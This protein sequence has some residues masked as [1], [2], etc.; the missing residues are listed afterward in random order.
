[1]TKTTYCP[2]ATELRES[3][4]LF[5]YELTMFHFT[6]NALADPSMESNKLLKNAILE[7]ALIHTRNLYEFFCGKES[8]NNNIIAG[9]FAKNSDGTPWKSPSLSFI[10]SC[11][12]KINKALSHLTYT[13]VKN[14]P[15]WPYI[16]IS[17]NIELAYSA[18]IDLLPELEHS[19]W[20]D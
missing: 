20:Q 15:L 11:K 17:Q 14:K 3:P 8:L 12:D 9:H 1:M 5:L 6:I 16:R 7:S 18:F 13:R 10:A 2:S 19:K 4:K